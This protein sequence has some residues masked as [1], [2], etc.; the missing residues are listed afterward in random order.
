[1]IFRFKPTDHT[2]YT[3]ELIRSSDN[4]IIYSEESFA[5]SG[6]YREVSFNHL[7]YLNSGAY[8]WR[9]NFA[10]LTNDENFYPM[11]VDKAYPFI[12][13]MHTPEITNFV[14]EPAI[15]YHGGTGTVVCYANYDFGNASYTWG[16]H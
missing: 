7:R 3:A 2:I 15:I 4:S 9:L 13:T 12:Y 16:S 14:K 10:P 6:F 5:Q 8:K 1:M 11:H